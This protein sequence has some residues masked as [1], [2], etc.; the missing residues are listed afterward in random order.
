MFLAGVCVV[1]MLTYA[2][3]AVAELKAAAERRL[4]VHSDPNNLQQLVAKV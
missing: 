1:C 2:D 3:V 4:G